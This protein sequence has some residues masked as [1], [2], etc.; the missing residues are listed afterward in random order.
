MDIQD[1]DL[2]KAVDLI[3]KAKK[4]NDDLM[5]KIQLSKDELWKDLRE[6]KAEAAGHRAKCEKMQIEYYNA[7]TKVETCLTL[8]ILSVMFGVVCLGL[9]WID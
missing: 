6:A 3:F 4:Q 1:S 9:L 7:K 8:A 2:M 5:Q